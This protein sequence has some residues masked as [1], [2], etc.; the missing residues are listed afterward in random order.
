MVHGVGMYLFKLS[1]RMVMGE[2]LLNLCEIPV[3]S[4]LYTVYSDIILTDR[5]SVNKEKYITK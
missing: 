5:N 3:S 2:L 4:A 1:D